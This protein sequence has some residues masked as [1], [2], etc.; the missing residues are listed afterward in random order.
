MRFPFCEKHYCRG[1]AALS[2]LHEAGA[3]AAQL[4]SVV[5]GD[6]VGAV[7]ADDVVDVVA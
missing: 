6:G 3:V 1:V 2:F 7:V 4:A 5:L